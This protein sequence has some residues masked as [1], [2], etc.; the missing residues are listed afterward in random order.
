MVY[1]TAQGR[2]QPGFS[3]IYIDS[4]DITGPG[5]VA[6]IG[7]S[8]SGKS[9]LLSVL[10]GLKAPNLVSA[11]AAGS[12]L[13]LLPGSDD[14]ADLLAGTPP[15]PGTVSFV[16]QESYLMKSLSVGLN[17]DMARAL[18]RPRLESARFTG[19]M[20]ELGLLGPEDKAQGLHDMRVSDL[21]GGQQQRIAVARALAA[22]PRVIFCDEPTSSLD[23]AWL[24]ATDVTFDLYT[25]HPAG[26]PCGLCHPVRNLRS[27]REIR[28]RPVAARG[29]AL[30][31]GTVRRRGQHC[32][33]PAVA[34]CGPAD[35]NRPNHPVYAR[36]RRRR[37][38]ATGVWQAAG[39]GRSRRGPTRELRWGAKPRG[40]CGA[41]RLRPC[42]AA[43]PRSANPACWRATDSHC[44]L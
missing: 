11:A 14:S 15:K 17:V 33:G 2:D 31:D 28:P 20:T 41:C 18:T 8:G 30:H 10:S 5:V 35:R 32:R 21:S 40:E 22:D 29:C 39:A 34:A 13:Q 25:D 26:H 42:R 19:L 1:R 37:T 43:V 3:G 12:Q 36:D 27:G 4:L 9:T 16:F 7:Q 23:A 6:V 24:A 44:C 38:I